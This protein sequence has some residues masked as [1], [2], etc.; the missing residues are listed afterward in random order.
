MRNSV[1]AVLVLSV[2]VGFG[3]QPPAKATTWDQIGSYLR[4]IQS[5][6]IEAMV[7]NDCPLGLLVLIT[8]VVKCC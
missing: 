3:A 1:L 4:L 5:A 6:G 7:A 2:A 8:P